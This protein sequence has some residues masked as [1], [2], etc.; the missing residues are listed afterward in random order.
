MGFLWRLAI[1]ADPTLKKDVFRQVFVLLGQAVMTYAYAIYFFVFTQLPPIGQNAFTLMLPL[2]KLALKNYFS[3]MLRQL[4]DLKPAFV[5]L[6]VD[7]FSAL[8][9]ASILQASQSRVNTTIVLAV[10]VV[11]MAIAVDDLCVVMSEIQSLVRLDK[12]NGSVL[13]LCIMASRLTGARK[14]LDR[15]TSSSRTMSNASKH[16]R[17]PAGIYLGTMLHLANRAFYPQL[18]ALDVDEL[19]LSIKAVMLNAGLEF[20]SFIFICWLIKRRLQLR[21]YHLLGFALEAQQELVHSSLIV[22]LLYVIQQSLAH[23]GM[24]HISNVTQLLPTMHLA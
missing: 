19:I 4:D 23:S 15:R 7:V 14:E 22:W 11:Q 17:T 10:D 18:A 5:V 16:N 2:L 8:Y 12:F 9:V 24:L 13:D 1:C 6:N 20:I 3:F 21:S